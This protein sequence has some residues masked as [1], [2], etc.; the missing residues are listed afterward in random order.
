MPAL[1]KLLIHTQ[2]CMVFQQSV[3]QRGCEWFAGVNGFPA[4]MNAWHFTRAAST[5]HV[6][7]RWSYHS[8]CY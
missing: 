1:W 6:S 5:A 2:C 3:L 7:G 4:F 8:R